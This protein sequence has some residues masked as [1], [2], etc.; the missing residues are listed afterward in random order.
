MV[1]DT[2][3]ISIELPADQVAQM[4][5]L[6]AAG[7][8]GSIASYVSEAVRLRLYRDRS[9][10]ELKELFDRKGQSPSEE[11]L[12]WARGVLGVA[13]DERPGEAS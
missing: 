10:S 6:V 9:L 1:D 3:R 12:A 2:E 5:E 11:H 4:R 8:T 13:G 7:E